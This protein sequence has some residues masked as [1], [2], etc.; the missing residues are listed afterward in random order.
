[1]HPKEIRRLVKECIVE[2]LQE[3]LLEAFDPTSQGP[4]Q[5]EENPYPSWN[6]KMRTMEETDDHGPSMEEEIKKKV[7]EDKG[8]EEY[9]A[10]PK[11]PILSPEESKLVISQFRQLS[12]DRKKI[13][14][15]A[16]Q[17]GCAWCEGQLEIP[18]VAFSHG[19]CPRHYVDMVGEPSPLSERGWNIPDLKNDLSPEELQ[20][21]IKLHAI[22]IVN[23]K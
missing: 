19:I 8:E 9:K 2:V 16:L 4:N 11:V 10:K 5:V 1:M 22:I 18:N 14:S 15:H 6:S 17:A 13:I 21:A 3:N 20:L 12:S 7:S 23:R